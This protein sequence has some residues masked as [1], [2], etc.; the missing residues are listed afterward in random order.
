M[1]TK[2]EMIFYEGQG[3]PRNKDC[4]TI[5]RDEYIRLLKIK[6][7]LIEKDD[8]R[9]EI[10]RTMNSQEK[11]IRERER[12]LSIEKYKI[13]ARIREFSSSILKQVEDI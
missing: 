9:K 2:E 8:A 11:T 6:E 13:S 4:V 12:K 3:S 10:I 1:S 7:G 5:K